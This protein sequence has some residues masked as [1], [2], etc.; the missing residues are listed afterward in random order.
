MDN[1]LTSTGG[2]GSL[3][4]FG[5]MC[6]VEHLGSVIPLTYYSFFQEDLVIV[7]GQYLG[8][9]RSF[10]GYFWVVFDIKMTDWTAQSVI[11]NR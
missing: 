4:N 6:L 3:L 11:V 5:K 2:Q 7:S 10:S 1:I 9:F 8:S